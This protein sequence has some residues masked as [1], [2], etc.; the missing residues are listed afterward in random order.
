MAPFEHNESVKEKTGYMLTSALA[1]I[2]VFSVVV[3]VHEVGH[4]LSARQAGIVI[5]E[6]GIG[7]PPRIATLFVRNGVEYTLNVIPLGG[8]VKLRGEEDPT[9]PGSFASKS[10]WVRIRTLGAGV[11]MNVLLAVVL[12]AGVYLIG[13]PILQGQIM[14]E[15]VLPYTPADDA[16]MWPGDVLLRIEG[17][18]VQS[19]TELRERVRS[20]AG[21]EIE[22]LLD[23]KGEP[24]SVRVTPRREPPAGQGA[25]GI[26]IAMAPGAVV[27]TERY[28]LWKAISRGAVDVV[29]TIR[30]M[31]AGFAQMFRGGLRA[32]DITGPVGIYQISGIVARN[33]LIS[34]MQWTGFLSL[35]LFLLN[36]LPIPGLDGG[37]IAFV[38]LEKVRGRRM[39]P[40]REGM[41]HVIGML[42]LLALTAVVSAFDIL[43]LLS[44]GS[45]LP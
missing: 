35:N 22:V 2:A 8:F 39:A 32:G 18:D 40:Q 10:A 20:L 31:I 14:V 1:F 6:F 12:F 25:L 7:Y 3:L 24:F 29:T 41:A 4:F 42:I 28:S 34:L 33:G 16:G 37:R 36:L 27:T 21:R 15:S 5:E 45:V 30:A 26:T 23:R 11:A 38:V 17:Q 44:G 13:K 9:E 43:R 19:F